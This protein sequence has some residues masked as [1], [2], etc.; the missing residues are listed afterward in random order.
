MK[1]RSLMDLLRRV[2]MCV[3]MH[4][5][6]Q[7]LLGLGLLAMA[8]AYSLAPTHHLSASRARLSALQVPRRTRLS[9]TFSPLMLWGFLPP[10]KAAAEGEPI[11]VEVNNQAELESMLF[12]SDMVDKLLVV[13]WLVP[14]PAPCARGEGVAGSSVLSSEKNTLCTKPV[15][16]Q[17]FFYDRMF[18]LA[19]TQAGAKYVYFS[20]PGSRSSRGNTWTRPFLSRLMPSCSSTTTVRP[21]RSVRRSSLRQS[22]LTIRTVVR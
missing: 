7:V 5:A 8:T 21:L 18:G 10:Q 4:P 3:F 6:L 15:L 16:H 1:R 2:P 14:L 20:S 19:G 13:D 12:R 9:P 11:I 22:C 17:L